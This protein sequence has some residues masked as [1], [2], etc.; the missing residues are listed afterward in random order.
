MVDLHDAEAAA[1]AEAIYV[2]A[3]SAQPSSAEPSL[4]K[5][6]SETFDGLAAAVSPRPRSNDTEA[7]DLAALSRPAVGLAAADAQRERA[8]DREGDRTP[9]WLQ[10]AAQSLA[11]SRPGSAK[12]LQEQQRGSQGAEAAPTGKALSGAVR[13]A[14]G[15]VSL[16]R[17]FLGPTC[18]KSSGT[19]ASSHQ[20]KAEFLARPSAQAAQHRP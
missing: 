7:Q 9:M 2:Q 4:R 20:T 14:V 19:V 5:R 13:D 15:S 3:R 1:R 8:Q 16:D 6:L 10:N 11:D 12:S 18:Q 17:V